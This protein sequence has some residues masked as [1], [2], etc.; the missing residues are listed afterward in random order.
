M[1]RILSVRE[2]TPLCT[3]LAFCPRPHLVSLPAKAIF[4]EDEG[5]GLAK[6]L[7]LW[8]DITSAICALEF[9]RVYLRFS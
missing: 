3:L 5:G 4:S 8:A 9:A 2:L 1:E 6:D 7:L